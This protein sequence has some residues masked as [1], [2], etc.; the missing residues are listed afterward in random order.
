[1]VTINKV[2]ILPDTLTKSPCLS[3]LSLASLHITSRGP[4]VVA[5]RTF[6]FPDDEVPTEISPVFPMK[7]S[8]FTL[9]APCI[10]IRKAVTHQTNAPTIAPEAKP[11]KICIP[12]EWSLKYI[13]PPPMAKDIKNAN[14]TRREKTLGLS[15]K[16]SPTST[17]SSPVKPCR[18]SSWNWFERTPRRRPCTL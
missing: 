6:A 11:T 17:P 2:P 1:M 9:L 14:M 4:D 7:L 16:E 5:I 3:F 13:A 15:S 18:R 10:F 8:E 12:R